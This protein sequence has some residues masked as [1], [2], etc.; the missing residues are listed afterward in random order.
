MTR[1]ASL[2]FALGMTMSATAAASFSLSSPAIIEG[3]RVGPAQI[4]D[5][6]GY[7]GANRSPALS[8]GPAPAG[9]KSF[10][11]TMFDPDAPRPGGWWHWLTIDIPATTMGLPEGMKAGHGLPP[12]AI[13]IEND[14][15]MADYG[16]PAPP[17]G[18]AHRYVFT[19][20]A[21]KV[22]KL[23]F[24]DHDSPARVAAAL[25][26]AKLAKASLTAKFGR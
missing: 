8:W 11:V 1:W 20:Y 13:Q 19:V 4:Y 6:F 2:L 22:A 16:G 10:A 17:P 14:F 24:G 7:S 26:A 9:T 12:G 25:E 15:G 21:L 3:G 23:G 5:G 18:K